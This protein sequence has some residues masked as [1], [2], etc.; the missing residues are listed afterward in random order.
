MEKDQLIKKRN[1]FRKEKLFK[2]ADETREELKKIG[3]EI[4]D[5]QQGTV[6][7]KIS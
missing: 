4:R 6:W 1:Q 3:V 2:E 5:S 7:K